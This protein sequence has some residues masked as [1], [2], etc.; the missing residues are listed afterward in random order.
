M[1]QGMARDLFAADQEGMFTTMLAHA[2]PELK[3][4]RYRVSKK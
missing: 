3:P 1:V 2:E 4:T